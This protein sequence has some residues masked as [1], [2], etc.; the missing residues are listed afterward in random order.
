MAE[1]AVPHVNPTRAGSK[2]AASVAD[3]KHAIRETRARLSE[4]IARSSARIEALVSPRS[5]AAVDPAEPGALGLV[6]AGVRS[7]ERARQSFSEARRSGMLRRVAAAATVAGIASA[8]IV[9]V[10]R[11]RA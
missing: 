10:R 3:A 5:E 2:P 8:V 1:P 11:R 6:I 7:V 9:Q 4:E